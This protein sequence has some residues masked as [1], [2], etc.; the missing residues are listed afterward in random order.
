VIPVEDLVLQVRGGPPKGVG[1]LRRLHGLREAAGVEA[2]RATGQGREQSVQIL[3]QHRL[4][5]ADAQRAVAEVTEVDARLQRGLQGRLG[6]LLRADTEGVE[7]DLREHLVAEPAESLGEDAGEGA[8]ALGDG[9]H[10]LGPVVHG[11]R[12]GHDGEE[13][14]GRADVG[15]GLFPAD[16]LLAGLQRHPQRRL[17]VRVDA[18]PDDAARH[19][20]LVGVLRGHVRGVGAAE[21]H[22]HAEALS[23]AHRD[24][25]APFARRRE[26]RQGHEVRSGDD[27]HAGIVGAHAEGTVVQ[28]PSI[29]G[30]VLHE[31]AEGALAEVVRLVVGHHHLDPQEP[32]A[33]PHH[34]NGLRVAQLGDEERVR[35]FLRLLPGQVHGLGGGGALVQ[36]RGVGDLQTREVDDQGLVVQQR[37]QAALR[38]LGLIRRVL[39]V[40]A[41]VLHDVPQDDPRDD[42]VRIPH[43]EPGAEHAVLPR[44][45][46]Q[47]ADELGLGQGRRQIQHA[48]EADRLGDGV[49]DEAVQGVVAEGVEH[50]P[51]LGFVGAEVAPLEAGGEIYARSH[52]SLTN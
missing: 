44:D 11:I 1:K 23:V 28:H 6:T 20:P 5:Q 2:R 38:D 4:V 30:R 8:Y 32:G 22:G 35:A 25:R 42:G 19:L 36:Q 45:L 9:A 21:A 46:P 26:Q 7:E 52:G 39:R 31:R 16:V 3:R 13:H 24:V 17:P 18:H 50:R 49:V 43:T 51:D 15:R 12:A 48:L 34:R 47:P 40:P 41:G 14:L 10:P 37:L 33:G 29:R 27:H